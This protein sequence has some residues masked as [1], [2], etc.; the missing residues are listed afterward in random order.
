MVAKPVVLCVLA[1][2]MSGSVSSPV[3]SEPVERAHFVFHLP[4]DRYLDF[5]D[6]VLTRTRLQLKELL[7][8]TVSYKAQVHIVEDL[9]QFRN[10]I[11]GRFPHWGAAAAYPPQQLIAIKSPDEF[12]VGK[13]LAELLAHEYAHLALA[14]R[15]GFYHAP[16][17]FEEGLAMM[18]STEWSWTDNLAISK[19]SA[20]GSLLPLPEIELV[21][22]FGETKA[23]TAY[24]QSYL[25]VK[26]FYDQYSHDAVNRFL[27]RIAAGDSY[28]KA[29]LASTGSDYA[30]FNEE[31]HSYLLS[32]YN[33]V[34]LLAD[35]MFLWIGLAIIVVIGA[36]LKFRKRRQYYKKW[37]EEEKLQATDFDYGDPDRPEKPDDDEP[38]RP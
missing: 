20:F 35:T 2:L 23:Q 9:D 12:N 15:T 6:S 8:D 1:C 38:W 21:N 4:T 26:Y 25:A 16:R 33:L 14:E 18:V 29:L 28:D 32:H 37:E 17:W 3:Q 19:A 5:S 11:R 10:L 30:E 27:D 7:Q 34:T 13:S 31:I 24:A 22:R 36:F